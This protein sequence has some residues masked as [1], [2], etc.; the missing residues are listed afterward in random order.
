[1]KKKLIFLLCICTLGAYAQPARPE[2]EH[3]EK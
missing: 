1:M 3:S 2:P